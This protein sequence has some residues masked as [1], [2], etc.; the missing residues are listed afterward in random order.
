MKEKKKKSPRGRKIFDGKNYDMI[1][2]KLE[3]AWGLGCSDAEAAFYADISKASLS[4]FITRTP[5]IAERK[6]LLKEKPILSARSTLHTSIKNGNAELA[7]KYLERKKS[8]EFG[9]KQK[10]ELSGG[11]EINE[12]LPDDI[13]ELNQT[14]KREIKEINNLTKEI[15]NK[16]GKKKV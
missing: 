11:L 3:T 8:E 4:E 7:F 2:R 14:I 1:I 6:A 9:P 12:D 13:G 10:V 15:A 16:S 5:K